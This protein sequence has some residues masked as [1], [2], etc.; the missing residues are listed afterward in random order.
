VA[1][2]FAEIENLLT[3]FLPKSARHLDWW[4]NEAASPVQSRAWMDAGYI[5][6][7]EVARERVVFRKT[8]SAVR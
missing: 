3:A 1:L 4:S 6:L 2:T 5:A 7:P 8:A